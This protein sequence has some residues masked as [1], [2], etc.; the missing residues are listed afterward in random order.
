MSTKNETT[1]EVKTTEASGNTKPTLRGRSFQITIHEIEKFEDWKTEVLK[2]KSLRYMLAYKEHAPTTGKEHIHV[3]IYFEQPYKYSK[4]LMAFNFHVEVCRG[5][6]KQNINYISKEGDKL[7]EYGEAPHQGYSTIADL[8]LMNYEDVL[9]QYARIKKE[10]DEE[11]Y[12]KVQFAN[13]LYEIK[14]DELKAPKVYYLTGASGKGKTYKAFK[15]ALKFYD[16][17]DICDVQINN[18]FFK[19][20]GNPKGKCHVIQEFRSSQL[21]ASDF[22]QYTDKYGFNANVK[23]GFQYIR[24]ECIII[25]SIIKP[26]ELYTKEEINA[27]FTRRITK[28]YNLDFEEIEELADI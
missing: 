14:R 11:T 20:T 13:M 12:E 21:H 16:V 7:F 8:R 18:N 2:L 19:F 9:P 28:T 4:K 10:L 25:C 23:G 5:S 17:E 27:Q 6:P 24:P 26:T 3:Y 22:L 1:T 15:L